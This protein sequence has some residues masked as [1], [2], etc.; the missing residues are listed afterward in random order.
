[1]SWERE[2]EWTYHGSCGACGELID[3]PHR[4]VSSDGRHWITVLRW[5]SPVPHSRQ[6]CSLCGEERVTL[7]GIMPK[8]YL[9]LFGEDLPDGGV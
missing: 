5:P 3:G 6:E 4:P 7:H 1:M 2:K 9:G 8:G